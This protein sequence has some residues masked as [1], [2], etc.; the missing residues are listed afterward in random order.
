MGRAALD[1]AYANA[2]HIPGSDAYPARWAALAA[3]FR[4]TARATLDIGYAPGAAFDLFLPRGTPLGLA[5]FVHG[6]YWHL[7]GKDDWSHLAAGAVQ[8]GFAM[9]VPG[10][11]LAPAAG[12]PAITGH[13][14]AA[15][16]AAAARVRGPIHLCGHS[17]GGHLVARMLMADAAPAAAD[18]IARCVPI[19]PVA[20]LR[21]LVPQSLNRTLRLDAAEAARESPVLG[22]PRGKARIAVH[23]GAAERPSFRWQAEALARAWQAPLRV[24]PGRHHFD[25]IEALGDPRSPML[26]DLLGAAFPF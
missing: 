4:A 19:S 5:V 14:A 3:D 17:A 22:R 2:A 26:D 9:A 24:A 7:F 6:G 15:V 13:V 23:V 8:R 18:R 1:D 16:D 20:D 10:Y 25:V 11:P 12:V 21:P